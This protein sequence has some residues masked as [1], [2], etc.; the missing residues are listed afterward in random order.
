[1]NSRYLEYQSPGKS[2]EGRDFHMVVLAKDKEAVDKYLNQTLP[3]AL[4]N[5]EELMKKIKD[6]TIG[7]YQVPVWF[8]NIHPDEIE[9]IDFQTEL[10][11]KYAMDTH[12]KFTSTDEREC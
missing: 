10:L 12:V 9:G 6:G 7:D 8:N 3:A 5:P 2:F 11:K 4:E 1:M